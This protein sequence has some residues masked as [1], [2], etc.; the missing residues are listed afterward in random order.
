VATIQLDQE[1]LDVERIIDEKNHDEAFRRLILLRDRFGRRPEYR[2]LKILF[3]ATFAVRT[4][5][6]LLSEVRTLVAEQQDFLEAVALLALLLDRTGDHERAIVFARE[7]LRSPNSRAQMRARAILGEQA[8]QEVGGP[9]PSVN[10]FAASTAREAPTKP[11]VRPVNV[12]AA[13]GQSQTRSTKALFAVA[14]DKQSSP[15]VDKAEAKEADLTLEGVAPPSNLDA[16]FAAVRP[17]E[18]NS[19]NLRLPS[20]PPIQDDR[21]STLEGLPRPPLVPSKTFS[22]AQQPPDSLPSTVDFRIS[23]SLPEQEPS[24]NSVGA[25]FIPFS[26]DQAPMPPPPTIPPGV[27]TANERSRPPTPHPSAPHAHRSSF[28]QASTPPPRRSAFPPSPE[29]RADIAPETTASRL[30]S[31]PPTR[32]QPTPLPPEYAVDDTGVGR[33]VERRRS[34]PS[35]QALSV[36][37][38]PEHIKGW[39]QFARQN[40]LQVV[41]GFSTAQMLLDLCE[42]VVEGATSLSSRPVPLDRRGLILVEEQLEALRG[43][44]TKTQPVAERGAVTAAASFLLGLLLKECDGRAADTSVED[45]AC[46]VTLPSGA[47]VRPLL[48]AAAFMRSRGP[49]LI[50]TFDRAATSHMRRNPARVTTGNAARVITGNAAR[51]IT[52]NSISQPPLRNARTPA[53]AA[54]SSFTVLRRDLDASTLGITDPAAPPAPQPP[55]DMRKVASEFWTSDLGREIIGSSRRVGTFTIADVD[56]IERHASK[57]FNAVGFSPPG[58]PWPWMPSEE[59]DDLI[60]AWGAILGEVLVSLYLG[61]WEADP[62]NPDDRFLFRVILSSGVVA[63]PVAKAYMR[64]ARGIPHDLTVY[65]DAVGR[66]VGRQALGARSWQGL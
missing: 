18:P 7:A 10:R 5:A 60:L 8:E 20:S 34:R 15:P 50:E 55:I 23:P 26:P 47:T 54:A 41:E 6:E 59:Q 29:P 46:K 12:P 61:R 37:Q 33:E 63:W 42:R 11:H 22:G 56:A 66:V 49:S 27:V 43:S 53:I 44:R 30:P 16:A 9:P 17:R 19:S 1:I 24:Q 38:P 3:D 31:T 65:I 2:Y 35:R 58:S 62:G 14:D 52:G 36:P 28:S 64:L 57:A 25:E 51:V 48:V 13:D 21:V 45:G 32:R 39:F 40:Q 4:D